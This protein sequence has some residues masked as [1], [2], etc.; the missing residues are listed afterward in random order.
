M[1]ACRICPR[2][3]GA[4]RENGIGAC[5]SGSVP[6]IARAALHMWEE[7]CISGKEGSG[8]IFFAGCPLGC[9]YCQNRQI[10]LGPDGGAV[11]PGMPEQEPD[12][13]REK[14][15]QNGFVRMDAAGLA[16][17]ALRLQAQ[18][19]NNINL[20]TAGHYLP[21]VVRMLELAGQQGLHIPVVWNSGGY[22]LPESLERLRG[23]V[24][25]FLPDLKYLSPETARRYSGAPDYPERAKAAIEKMAELAGTPQFDSR[26]IMTR[27]MVVRHLLLPGHTGEA[28]NVIRYLHETYGESIYI[29]IMNQYT[30]MP[31]IER[32][33]PELGRRVTRR[34]YDK[35]IDYAIS[36][37][38]ENAFIQTGKTAKESYIPAF[39]G[40]GI[41]TENS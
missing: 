41:C 14:N 34:E 35:V 7:P 31:G 32:R 13:Q 36:I 4:D 28:K 40:T 39:D 30:P 3:C 16:G 18:G 12:R 10:A 20:V 8:A 37:G 15:P 11:N 17:T 5:R 25:V 9:V 6:V 2:N 1:S 38:V 27:G 33:F 22:E 24:S 29:S 21:E 26:G 19:A 23:W